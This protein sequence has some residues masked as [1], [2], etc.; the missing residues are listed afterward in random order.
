MIPPS[1]KR[2]PRGRWA[3]AVLVLPMLAACGGAGA[4]RF[5]TATSLP[6]DERQPDGIAVDL[7]SEPPPLRDRAQSSDVLVTLRTPLGIDV[8]KAVVRRFFDSVTREDM[9]AMQS[10]VRFSAV[11]QDTRSRSR[12]PRSHGLVTLWRRR[13]A[14][15]DHQALASRVI[16]READVTVFH[17]AAVDTLPLEVKY[18]DPSDATEPSDVVLK[19]P[20]ATPIIKSE[21]LFGD[22]LY[23][24]LRRDGDRYQI[25]R[26]AEAVPL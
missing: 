1:C 12:G 19:V 25:Y 16:Y 23:F 6:D 22:E 13:F 9:A 26:M 7:S 10:L 17:G 21:R 3:L 4:P 8:A 5:P 18:L 15:R 11:V 24:W 2:E 20:I 14:K